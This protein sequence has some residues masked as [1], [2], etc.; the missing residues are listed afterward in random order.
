MYCNKQVCTKVVHAVRLTP[1]VVLSSSLQVRPFTGTQQG[2]DASWVSVDS[3]IANFGSGSNPG[4][5]RGI[6]LDEVAN[7][8]YLTDYRELGGVGLFFRVCALLRTSSAAVLLI[9]S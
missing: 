6:A 1:S 9:V 3:S 5:L 8:L 2:A 4:S 7:K